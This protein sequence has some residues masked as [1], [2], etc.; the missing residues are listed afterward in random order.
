MVCGG[1][2]WLC[3]PTRESDVCGLLKRTFAYC[4]H[5]QRRVCMMQARPSKDADQP[6]KP[7]WKCYG[8]L[9]ARDPTAPAPSVQKPRSSRCRNGAFL[10]LLRSCLPRRARRHT[11]LFV[12]LMALLTRCIYSSAA[13]CVACSAFQV[14]SRTIRVNVCM[15]DVVYVAHVIFLFFRLLLVVASSVLYSSACR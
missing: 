13:C 11:V 2:C 9:V 3:W 4:G 7:S 10:P 1:R 14:L 15:S 6:R 8:C 12:M 5:C